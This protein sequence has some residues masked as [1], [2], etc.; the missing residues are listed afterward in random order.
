MFMNSADWD[1]SYDLWHK[2]AP[3]MGA[4]YGA[5]SYYLI[6]IMA[7]TTGSGGATKQ[8]AVFALGAFAIGYSQKQ[9][10]NLTTQIFE[11]VFRP[12]KKPANGT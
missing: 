12:D 11:L 6:E 1:D 4:V 7:T 2:F 9:F 5:V 10:S 8:A 3:V